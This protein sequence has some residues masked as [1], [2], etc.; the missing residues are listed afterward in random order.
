MDLE[1][2]MAQVEET[3]D[4]IGQG[5]PVPRN[6]DFSSY[7]VAMLDVYIMDRTVHPDEKFE[8]LLCYAEEAA[9]LPD[10]R[11][12]L[13]PRWQKYLETIADQRLGMN[14]ASWNANG[15]GVEAIDPKRGVSYC[16]CVV[17]E[18]TGGAASHAAAIVRERVA[19]EKA[20]LRV[21]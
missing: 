21:N 4:A 2:V 7:G 20:R 12:K 6:Y 14:P 5:I 8:V 13:A 3:A 10:L 19:E 17:P 16:N 1:G 18:E 15:F 9:R 11:S